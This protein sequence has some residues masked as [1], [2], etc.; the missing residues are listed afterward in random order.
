M[1]RRRRKQQQKDLQTSLDKFIKGCVEKGIMQHPF[2]RNTQPTI[3]FIFLSLFCSLVFFGC[4]I[5][6]P[7]HNT[8][9]STNKTTINPATVPKECRP[10]ANAL[11]I[12]QNK[13]AKLSKDVSDYEAQVKA[14]NATYICSG[15]NVNMQN[16]HAMHL[17]DV[18]YSISNYTLNVNRFPK[19]CSKFAGNATYG[20]MLKQTFNRLIKRLNGAIDKARDLCKARVSFNQNGT[21]SNLHVKDSCY[22]IFDRVQ[23]DVETARGL[24]N[25]INKGF[26]NQNQFVYQLS[27]ATLYLYRLNNDENVL[28]QLKKGTKD[29]QSCYSFFNG[30]RVKQ[31]VVEV[32]QQLNQSYLKLKSYEKKGLVKYLPYLSKINASYVKP[33]TNKIVKGCDSNECK[34]ERL[35]DYVITRMHYES[36]PAGEE[37]IKSPYQTMQ[38][39]GGDCEDLSILYISMLEAQHIPAYLAFTNDHVY[40]V[41]CGLDMDDVAKYDEQREIS[42]LDKDYIKPL[43]LTNVFPPHTAQFI[44]F[45]GKGLV[46]PEVVYND[47]VL[48]ITVSSIK[49]DYN[50]T[51]S[52]HLELYAVKDESAFEKAIQNQPFDY[53]KEC[54]V[55]GTEIHKTC[56]LSHTLGGVLALNSGSGTDDVS[57]SVRIY[58]D[59]KV[60]RMK[61]AYFTVDGKKCLIAETTSGK[62]GVLGLLNSTKTEKDYVPVTLVN[63]LTEEITH[64]QV[65]QFKV[66]T[67]G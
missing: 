45:T 17:E 59:Y 27:N 6:T 20:D 31:N 49:I 30:D 58:P 46:I 54:S 51:S 13:L 24:V 62:Y 34:A 42:F 14:Y 41:V 18:Q 64:P 21:S 39:W 52:G 7:S 5:S 32:K 56:E 57:G 3:F 29:N 60:T 15:A 47:S 19:E 2:S 50:I 9:S 12:A 33:L 11:Q 63:P 67:D 35:F 26:Q 37:L 61:L 44:R 66:I 38:D 10:L 4:T 23:T 22:A 16:I 65:M 25:E 1:K 36:D 53:Y 28:Q 48:T 8:H 55:E 40:V 43:K